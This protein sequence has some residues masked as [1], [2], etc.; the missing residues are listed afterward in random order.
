M[1]QY[2]KLKDDMRHARMEQ[3]QLYEKYVYAKIIAGEDTD[4]ITAGY[5]E[6]LSALQGFDVHAFDRTI[7][8]IMH[9]D[10]EQV[11]DHFAEGFKSIPDYLA[12]RN[13]W[14]EKV[15]EIMNSDSDA[16][17]KQMAVDAMDRARTRAHNGVISLFNDLNQYAEDN[18]IPKPYPVKYGEFRKDNLEHRA[19]VADILTRQTTILEATQEHVWKKFTSKGKTQTQADKFDEIFK[20][21]GL[22]GLLKEVNRL[23]SPEESVEGLSDFSKGGIRL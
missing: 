8:K 21:K 18:G 12:E 22:G 14:S 3:D 4:S 1:V 11:L 7:H 20:S 9:D 16:T 10:D 5:H 17:S 13:N 6:Y 23:N 19:D 2:E 15:K